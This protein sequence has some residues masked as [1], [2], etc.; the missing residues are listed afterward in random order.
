MDEKLLKQNRPHLFIE[1]PAMY[2]KVPD[3]SGKTVLCLGCGSGEECRFLLS[4]NPAKI[5]GVDFSENLIAIARDTVPDVEFEVMDAES[6]KFDNE[7]F[8]FVYSSLV[9]GHIEKWNRALGEVYRVLKPGGILLFS[10]THPVKKAARTVEDEDGKTTSALLGYKS[11]PKTG[12]SE[13]WGDYLNLVLHKEIWMK[14]I[15]A[16]FYTRPLS[17]MFREIV[18][19]RFRVLDI[20]EPRPIVETKQYDEEYWKIH[21][22]I[23]SFVI[24]ECKKDE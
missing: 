11:D 13:V 16:Y 9:F 7:T 21:Q 24:F 20:V 19:A 2:S 18:R 1:K 4:K 14:K 8:D 10:Q 23:P 5:C 15:D 17:E 3:L 12:K 22:K 6:L